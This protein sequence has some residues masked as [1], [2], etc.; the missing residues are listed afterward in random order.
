MKT[1]AAEGA[2]RGVLFPVVFDNVRIPFEFR[3]I[4][5]AQMSDWDGTPEHPALVELLNSLASIIGTRAPRG[6]AEEAPAD[7][8]AAPATA[9]P[10]EE[11]AK[12]TGPEPD[13][14]T[15]S[16]GTA[17][18]PRTFEPA[19][20]SGAAAPPSPT[21]NQTPARAGPTRRVSYRPPARPTVAPGRA[22]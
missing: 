16:P 9:R 10:A 3:R 12:K 5:A 18:P 17:P 19:P 6:S 20:D 1:E 2:E 11:D 21:A 22:S 13:G 15:S 4:Q 14:H 7:V 8:P